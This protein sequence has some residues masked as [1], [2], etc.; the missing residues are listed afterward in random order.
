MVRLT[1]QLPCRQV[2]ARKLW[3]VG[4]SVICHYSQRMDH[5]P[6]ASW[7][8]TVA[9]KEYAVCW[10]FIIWYWLQRDQTSVLNQI[11]RL[12][13]EIC[14]EGK[15]CDVNV[16]FCADYRCEIRFAKSRTLSQEQPH[17]DLKALA[18]G[19]FIGA[20][21]QKTRNKKLIHPSVFWCS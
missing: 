3:S 12:N 11:T 4:I 9:Y 10:S 20:V 8:S 13:N 17:L 16:I 2:I 5:R 14:P 19:W 1:W 7:H 21:R 6:P 18:D 15:L